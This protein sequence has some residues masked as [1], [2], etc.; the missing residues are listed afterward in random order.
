MD[1]LGPILMVVVAVLGIIGAIYGAM[2]DR[3]RVQ[4]LEG[5][6]HLGGWAFNPAKYD[7]PGL[8]FDLFKQGHSRWSRFHMTKTFDEVTPGL[9]EMGVRLF[10]YHYAETT[11]SGKDRRTHHYYFTC[12][13][14]NSGCD[15]GRVV[16]RDE[17]WGDKLVQAIGFDDID[18]ED[19]QF[20]GKFVVNAP[21]RKDA[22]DLLG[23]GLMRFLL[24]NG[25][26]RIETKGDILF[27]Y[28]RGRMHAQDCHRLERFLCGFL[29]Q[30]PRTMVNA[31]RARRG[32]EPIMEAGEA[33][34]QSRES[35]T[36]LESG[37]FRADET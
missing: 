28:D 21:E 26:W 27:V 4:E 10:E 19:A 23:H 18:L 3:K 8:A 25:G 24:R 6:A 16:I 30:V 32:L 14:V 20:S 2:A 11:G 1:F 15:L 13:V 29:A 33:S 31:E 12:G 36:R 22:Y 37:G 9:S 5:W 7:V 34:R 35:L 17:H